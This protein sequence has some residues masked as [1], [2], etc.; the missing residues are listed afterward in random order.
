M[1]GLL[2]VA[3][4]RLISDVDLSVSSAEFH[5]DNASSLLLDALLFSEPTVVGNPLRE[6]GVLEFSLRP[7]LFRA[8]DASGDFEQPHGFQLPRPEQM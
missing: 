1:G 4:K 7:N 6:E 8:G 5:L 2:C 3:T